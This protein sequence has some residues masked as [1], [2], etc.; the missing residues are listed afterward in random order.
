M[1]QSTK[2]T[3]GRGQTISGNSETNKCNCGGNLTK[4]FW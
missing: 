4:K 2:I 1:G 3:G